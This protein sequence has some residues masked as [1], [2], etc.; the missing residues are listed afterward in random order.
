M[1]ESPEFKDLQL[2]PSE[3]NGIEVLRGILKAKTPDEV[4]RLTRGLEFDAPSWKEEKASAIAV[5]KAGEAFRPP[6]QILQP[7]AVVKQPRE[8]EPQVAPTEGRTRKRLGP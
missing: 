6:P 3:K 1:L 7:P 2:Q 8:D 4:A 5:G